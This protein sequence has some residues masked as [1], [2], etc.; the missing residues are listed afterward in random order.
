MADSVVIQKFSHAAADYDRY[1]LVQKQ[2][3][4]ELIDITCKAYT[5]KPVPSS[6]LELGCGT[7]I[8]SQKLRDAFPA[9]E[10]VMLDASPEMLKIA[11][12]KLVPAGTT[13]ICTDAE[14]FNTGQYDLITSCSVL[15]WFRDL[16][17]FFLHIPS[18]LNL[19]GVLTFATYGPQTYQELHWAIEYATGKRVEIASTGFPNVDQLRNLLGLGA[20]VT[21]AF[22]TYEF[23]TLKE[24]LVSIK[25]TGTRGFGANPPQRWTRGLLERVEAAY[26]ERYGRIV[27]TSQLIYV[28]KLAN[29]AL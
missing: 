7:G 5:N 27:V 14:E 18:M 12:R 15:H 6:I 13:F 2:A 10:I 17:Q 24:L 28:S 20:S 9:A 25:R 8:Y 26:R 29:E 22:Y 19:N 4:L 3:A 23:D 16:P 11:K 1:A 21:E